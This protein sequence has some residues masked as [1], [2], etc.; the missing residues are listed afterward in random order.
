MAE[1]A[2]ALVLGTS[3][4]PVQVQVLLSAV[5]T[6]KYRRMRNISESVLF[7][8]IR[9]ERDSQKQKL[10]LHSLLPLIIVKI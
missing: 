5:E 1:L 7:C 8:H 3:G 10:R 4:H 2:D 9:R 6:E